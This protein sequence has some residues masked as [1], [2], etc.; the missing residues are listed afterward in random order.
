ISGMLIWFMVL[1]SLIVF[2]VLLVKAFKSWGVV[3]T[4]LLSILFIESWTFIF[5]AGGLSR[6][7]IAYTK[8]HDTLAA[9]VDAL[10][11]EVDMEM[12]GDRLDPKL[13]LTKF[14]P[15][16]NELNRLTLERGRVWRG[17]LLQKM[18][19]A[20]ANSQAT[21]VFQLPA[22]TSNVPIAA[23]AATAGAATGPSAVDPGLS[24]DSVVYLFGE[25][26]EPNGK[27][28][29]PR[30]YLAEFLVTEIQELAITMRP[31]TP[32]SKAQE[33]ILTGS[34]SWAI[35]ELMPLDSHT[36]FAEAT[37]SSE[38]NAE[39]GRMDEGMI[40]RIFEAPF[41]NLPDA[42]RAKISDKIMQAYLN[43]GARAPDQTPPEALGYR[44][45]FIQDYSK[46]VDAKG[47]RSP[48]E[49]G[50][51]DTQGSMIDAR[52]KR[53]WDPGD[54]FKEFKIG[55]TYV[56]DAATANRLQAEKVV[57]LGPPV[58]LRPLNDYGFAFRETRRMDIRANQDIA[59]IDRE[60]KE[61]KRSTE[62]TQKQEILG[63]EEGAKLGLDKA[64][65]EKESEVIASVA[66]ELES[67]IKAKTAELSQIYR[68]INALHD[69][70]LKQHREMARP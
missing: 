33:T 30:T 47:G 3:H 43:D 49:G 10:S 1:V 32:L 37:S 57:E 56:F 38:E 59:L 27:G 55:S 54:G 6:Y 36:A 53:D 16:S 63:E 41:N 22:P 4:I 7:R 46:P 50:Y 67:Q 26:L 42:M 44:V 29:I 60:Y 13:D 15:L 28:L 19:P 45:K 65:Y 64:M 2:I 14:A 23:P 58:Y 51:H 31:T 17:A 20:T 39:F 66:I 70:L 8:L 40:A 11:K 35:Y 12:N 9:K 61:A 5:F 48:L 69:L 68:N 34:P 52:L 24:V 25:E 62:E 21:A 18:T